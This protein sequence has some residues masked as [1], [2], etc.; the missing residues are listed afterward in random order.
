[1]FAV[2]A[3]LRH[4]ATKEGSDVM[5]TRT[6]GAIRTAWPSTAIGLAVAISGF[7]IAALQYGLSK[8]F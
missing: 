6:V 3:K 2:L 5:V 1:M 4:A 8:L 7:W